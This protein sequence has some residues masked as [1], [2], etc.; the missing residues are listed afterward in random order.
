[1][2]LP[3]HEE[4]GRSMAGQDFSKTYYRTANCLMSD[5]IADFTPVS[6][7]LGVDVSAGMGTV[8][9]AMGTRFDMQYVAKEAFMATDSYEADTRSIDDVPVAEVMRYV[10][11]ELVDGGRL[12]ENYQTLAERILTGK[13]VYGSF[14]EMEAGD[15]NARIVFLISPASG[16]AERSAREFLEVAE[17]AGKTA[18]ATNRC[19]DCGY[20]KLQLGQMDAANRLAGELK[21]VIGG[22]E[23]IVTDDAY[24]LDA[25][26]VLLPELSGR[27]KFIDAFL[28]E[29][30]ETLPK[31]AGRKI[32][33]HESGIIERLY[34]LRRIDY[35]ELLADA[36]I[37]LPERSGY[38][39]TDSGLAGGLGLFETDN[40]TI[41]S[42]RRMM[43]LSGLKA[44]VIV[45]PCAC[46]A[47]GLNSCQKG[48]VV[49]LLDYLCGC[50]W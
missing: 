37:V 17:R 22:Y 24:V 16:D 31:V 40:L 12:L 15:E 13:S 27:M 10:R 3:E 28:L 34:P 21:T 25:L 5:I 50:E 35:K 18:F 23:E 46:E 49:T 9:T 26:M 20:L 30:K 48:K 4:R 2:P 36:E 29:N 1:M 11:G 39:V 43:D 6:R 44:D 19:Q 33:L 42:A 38:D 41:I 7:I 14:R 45:T 32:A 47:A 8:F